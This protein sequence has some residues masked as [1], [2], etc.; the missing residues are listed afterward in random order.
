MSRKAFEKWAEDKSFVLNIREQY[1]YKF[2]VSVREMAWEVWQ[3]A[4]A[5]AVSVTI[6]HISECIFGWGLRTDDG[7][8]LSMDDTDEIAEY[9]LRQGAGGKE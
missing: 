9:I 2:H 1:G 8:N 5:Q 6:S 7:D 3:E 4:Q